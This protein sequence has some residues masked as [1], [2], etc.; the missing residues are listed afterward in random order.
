M[1]ERTMIGKKRTVYNGG[2]VSDCDSNTLIHVQRL[3]QVIFPKKEDIQ[4]IKKLNS[5]RRWNC[6]SLSEEI[7]IFR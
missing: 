2:K 3:W 4:F 1:R 5:R 6:P 7:N